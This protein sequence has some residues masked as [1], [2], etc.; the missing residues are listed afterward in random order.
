MCTTSLTLASVFSH[1]LTTS[2]YLQDY[3]NTAESSAQV[4]TLQTRAAA[5][6]RN[7]A[8]NTKNHALLIQAGAVDPLAD[9]MRNAQV[10]FVASSQL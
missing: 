9:I 3:A 10:G 2:L 8:H 6:I 7:L 4:A 1:K 5:V